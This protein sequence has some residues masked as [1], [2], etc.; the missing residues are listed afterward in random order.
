MAIT[1]GLFLGRRCR[2]HG[3][4]GDAQS[5]PKQQK[6]ST[7]DRALRKTGAKSVVEKGIHDETEDLKGG[8]DKVTRERSR[9]LGSKKSRGMKQW[10]GGTVKIVRISL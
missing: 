8:D 2:G 1:V 9:R 3:K 10:G 4:S 7:L 5:N 6:Q